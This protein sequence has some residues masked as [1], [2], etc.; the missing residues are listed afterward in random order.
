[1]QS[2][3]MKELRDS[4]KDVVATPQWKKIEADW[5]MLTE[6]AM[7]QTMVN[8]QVKLVAHL[9]ECLHFEGKDDEW[10]NPKYSPVVHDTLYVLFIYFRA[11]GN[12]DLKPMLDF[13]ID[14]KIEPEFE[15]H[16]KPEYG[17]PPKEKLIDP[18]A[19]KKKE[20]ADADTDALFLFW[21]ATAP[22]IEYATFKKM[23]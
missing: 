9:M 2:E 12:G 4:A 10:M 20:D 22:L 1:M 23:M 5:K 3:I 18:N 8:D 13:V 14:G 7:H 11:I 15:D 6:S 19:P 17:A 16:L 21:E